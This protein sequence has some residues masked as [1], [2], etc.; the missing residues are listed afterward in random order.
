M[1]TTYS[2]NPDVAIKGQPVV[3]PRHSRPLQL[4]PLQQILSLSIAAGAGTDDVVL[5]LTD[6]DTDQDWTLTVTGNA[7]EATLGAAIRAAVAAD[8]KFNSLVTVAAATESSGSAIVHTY[9]ARHHGRSYSLSASGGPANGS[10][11]AAETQA[12]G[13]SGL[14]FGVLVARGSAD[15]EFTAM[16]AS[17]TVRDIAG[18]LFRTDGNHFHDLPADLRNDP[19][20]G[21]D[22]CR[23]GSVYSIAEEGEFWVQV[24]EAV[25]RDSRPHVRIEGTSVGDWGDTPAGT[26]QVA[27]GTVVADHQVYQV[28]STVIVNG[29]EIPLEFSYDPTDGTTTTDDVV[30]GL[31]DAAAAAITAAGLTG[32]VAASTASASAT[33]T[34]TL[35]A[36]YTW[37]VS[38]YFASWGEDTE[39]VAGTFDA[40]TA[41][42]DMLDVSS[43]CR[44]T[45]SA[46]AGGLAKV[47]IRV[48]P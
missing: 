47:K 39:A 14:Q 3:A 37:G 6:L 20:S 16:T 46:S 19:A 33:F 11:T 31:E 30:D 34:L 36:G 44:Y 48:Q 32:I 13:G 29:R 41:D 21:V 25:T 26:A 42:V 40:G 23:P 17:T 9:T 4:A 12:A 35:T 24:Q 22:A 8:P 28:V 18:F 15:D 45:S 43:I 27:T 7:N 2:I 5:T 1:Q 10:Y 38:P